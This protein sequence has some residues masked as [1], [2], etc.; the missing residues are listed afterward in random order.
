M[1]RLPKMSFFSYLLKNTNNPKIKLSRERKLIKFE[2]TFGRKLF[3]K[4][5][6]NRQRE[7][8][9]LDYD[10]WVWYEKIRLSDGSIKENSIK[11][12]LRERDILKSLNGELYSVVSKDETKNLLTAI[13][14]YVKIIQNEY[15]LI[16]TGLNK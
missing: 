10:T 2:S 8:F 6:Q 11:Y 16:L 15:D 14:E 7:F 9:C 13:K 4:I 1:R 3:G 5:D 12:L